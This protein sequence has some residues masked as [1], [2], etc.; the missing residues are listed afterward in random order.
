MGL[1]NRSSEPK[2]LTPTSPYGKRPMW[3]TDGMAATGYTGSEPLDVVGE[4]F[5]QDELWTVAK[6][7]DGS[8]RGQEVRTQVMAMLVAE[9]GNPYDPNAV[10]VWIGG[11]P[12]GYLP[13]PIAPDMR[14]AI[15]RLQAENGQP[16]V[17]IGQVVGGGPDRPNLGVFLDYD[18][19][20]FGLESQSSRVVLPGEVGTGLSEL[21]Y[22][23]GDRKAWGIVSAGG[24]SLRHLGDLRKVIA[25]SDDPIIRHFAYASLEDA[26]YRGRE[27]GPEVLPQYDAACDAHLAVLPQ[28]REALLTALGVVPVVEV[29]RQA[30]IRWQKV[31]DYQRSLDWARSGIDFYSDAVERAGEIADLDRRLVRCQGK[32]DPKSKASRPR[33]DTGSGG[34]S[35]VE[36]LTCQTCGNEFQRIVTPGRKPHECPTCRGEVQIQQVL[37]ARTPGPT[38]S[39]VTDG[40]TP[41]GAAASEPDP[42]AAYNHDSD[43]QP[44]ST[45]PPAGWFENPQDPTEWRYW[46]GSLWTDHV[47]PR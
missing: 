38:P 23:S 28:T 5:H 27:A 45:L 18:P 2:A 34:E 41:R 33:K 39:G 7:L 16:V 13:R 6:V 19:A 40:S 9:E 12:V 26:L 46:D 44:Q 29:F 30:S 11:Y 37:T 25:T 43:V 10:A 36:V 8:R 24:D 4:S 42:V 35:A 47:A 32:L 21:M 15:I 3:M 1:F 20:D 31:H 17:L 22:R 14:A